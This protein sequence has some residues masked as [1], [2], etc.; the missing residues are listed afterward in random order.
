MRRRNLGLSDIDADPHSPARP[1][2]T[3]QATMLSTSASSG[4]R[5]ASAAGRTVSDMRQA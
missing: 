3:S 5:S 2:A 1:W 4:S